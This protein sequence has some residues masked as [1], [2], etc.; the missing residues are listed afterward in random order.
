MDAAGLDI[1]GVTISPLFYLYWAEPHIGL[2]SHDS[3]T[4]RW[5]NTATRFEN[6][7]FSCRL[8]PARRGRCR[9]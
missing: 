9:R 6:A 8:S 7:C 5:L 2:D 4:K 1:M 3:K